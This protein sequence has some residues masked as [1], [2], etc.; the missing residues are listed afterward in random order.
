MSRQRTATIGFGGWD[1]AGPGK[2]VANAQ[3]AVSGEKG[4]YREFA[5]NVLTVEIRDFWRKREDSPSG[6]GYHYHRNAETYM[7]VGD[8]LGRGMV[9]LLEGK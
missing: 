8:V 4:E 5:G 3:L 6:Q 1:L 9:K 7:L 2:T